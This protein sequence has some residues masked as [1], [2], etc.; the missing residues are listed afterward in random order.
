MQVV[1]RK[2][3]REILSER[4]R[5]SHDGGQKFKLSEFQKLTDTLSILNYA[6]IRLEFIDEGSSR[7]VYVLTGNKVLK[8]ATNF[9]GIDQNQ[10]EVDVFT[11]P[12][13]KPLTTR[14][15]DYNEKFFWI[16]SEMVK[17]FNDLFALEKF[18]K[19][20]DKNG[21]T[22]DVQK[23]NPFNPNEP[24]YEPY[25]F[26]DFILDAS[27]GEYE[28]ISLTKNSNQLLKIAKMIEDLVE[29]NDIEIGDLMKLNSWGK[30]HDQ[31][32]V[33]LDYGFSKT[34]RKDHYS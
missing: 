34:V 10:Q 1:L 11:D 7:I 16:I 26:H 24:F 13:T 12:R 19:L 2:L 32:F 3:V 30:S 28:N 21:M 14:I 20:R 4:I 33:L 22:I 29:F 17:P 5:S 8:I 9:A 31:R 15:F 25:Y 18:L 27:V 23:P 6:K